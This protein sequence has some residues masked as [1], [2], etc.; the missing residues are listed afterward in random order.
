MP[1][2][3]V[4]AIGA[5][6]V[7]PARPVPKRRGFGVLAV[8]LGLTLSMLDQV[9]VGTALP[10]IVGE[11]G[12]LNELSWVVTA[13]L[14]ASAAVIPIWGKLSDLY[15][16]RGAFLTAI[17]VFLAGSVGS[18]LAQSMTQI[19][20]FRALQG[21][22]SAGLMVGTFTLIGHLATGP[23]DRIR[24]QTMIGVVMPLAMGTGPMLGGLL[25]EHVGWRWSFFINVPLCLV[26]LA[27]GAVGIPRSPR[28]PKV[29]IDLLGSV[30]LTG[31]IVALT[32]LLSW[33]GTRYAWDSAPIIGLGVTAVVLLA[34]LPLVERR[35]VEPILPS[36][37]FHTRDF[38][39]AQVL[40]LLVG[41]GLL[42]ALVYFPQYLQQVLDVSPTTSGLLLLPF[43]IGMIIMELVVARLAVRTGPLRLHSVVGA[44]V[45]V[46]GVLLLLLLGTG[47]GLVAATL[48]PLTAGLGIGVLMQSSLIISFACQT[49]QRDLGAASGLINLFRA[50]GGS[51]GVALLGSLYTNRL[52]HVLTDRLG[53]EAGHALAAASG[54]STPAEIRALPTQVHEAFQAAVVAG[55]HSVVIGMTVIGVLALV[56]SFFFRR[57]LTVP[58]QAGQ[59]GQ[60][61][62]S[63]DRNDAPTAPDAG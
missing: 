58:G 1:D 11:L 55:L 3:D 23:A 25:T 32:L 22:G 26:A 20:A 59:A 18:G 38:T 50:I 14:V 60:A 15:G 9:I 28:R 36:R 19:I 41:A 13:Y 40:G 51:L 45:A 39:L 5:P 4:V 8:L 56:T 12:G 7:A 46:V 10:T 62:G 21:L 16:R 24:M 17:V 35:A 6:P 34:A 57:R 53:P 31:G 33:A 48:L 61:G 47:T 44:I 49:D 37:L 42:G 43:L 30:Q 52:E 63:R 27:A 29:R 2:G 54:Q